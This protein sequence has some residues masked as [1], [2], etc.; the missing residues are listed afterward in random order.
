MN[1]EDIKRYQRAFEQGRQDV[2]NKTDTLEL[3]RD[4]KEYE[5][6]IKGRKDAGEIPVKVEPRIEGYSR[7]TA[8]TENVNPLK[9][10][11]F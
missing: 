5:F 8:E 10:I 6:Y 1:S 9:T 4:E 2:L 3:A 11:L 7:Q